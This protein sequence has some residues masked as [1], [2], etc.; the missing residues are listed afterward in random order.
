MIG[1]RN[2]RLLL[3]LLVG[4][5]AAVVIESG[6]VYG[7]VGATVSM[8]AIVLACFA[9]AA[10]YGIVKLLQRS[11]IL[12]SGGS[13]KNHR[14]AASLGGHHSGLSGSDRTAKLRP[15]TEKDK[16]LIM[17]HID[18]LLQACRYDGVQRPI[19]VEPVSKEDKRMIMGHLDELLE[20]GH[21]HSGE[22]QS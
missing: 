1:G 16:K 18:D 17:A 2:G 11:N 21:E 19:Q 5:A 12:H 15:V 8:G 6:V 9:G 3:G 14:A 10:T 7:F 22:V 20:M 13:W 4:A